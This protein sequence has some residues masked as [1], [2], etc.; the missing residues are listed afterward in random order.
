MTSP[1]SALLCVTLVLIAGCSSFGPTTISRDRFD[2]SGALAKSW[3]NQ[4]L[5]NLVKM[6]Y[7]DLPIYL[8]VGQIVSGYSVQTDLTAAG[9]VARTGAGDTF[10]GLGAKGTFTDR[11]TMTYTP[12][13]GRNSRKLSHADPPGEGVFAGAIRLRRRLRSGAGR[14]FAERAAKPAGQPRGAAQGGLGVLPRLALLRE[15]QDAVRWVCGW[16]VGDAQ[17]VTVLFFRRDRIS[18]D[19]PAKIAEVRK[20]LGLTPGD[21]AFRLVASP[22]PGGPGESGIATRSS[23]RI[24]GA[25]ALGVEI[26]PKHLQRRLAPTIPESSAEAPLLRVHSGSAEPDDA[27]VAVSYEG[28][29]SWVA[30]DDWRSKRALS[31]VLFLLTLADREAP[32]C[33][34]SRSRHNEH[35]SPQPARTIRLVVPRGGRPAALAGRPIG[36]ISG[37][38]IALGQAACPR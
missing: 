9:Q 20:L 4:M 36:V 38:L 1:R 2:Y 26:P 32:S 8:E 3:K 29:W 21:H 33:P 34:C 5:L 24:L 19:V 14:G 27:F 31:S 37:H 17:A 35:A 12:L 22:L 10:L 13:T 30:N 18:P 7:L 15:I 11:P 16:S 28:E 23:A 6:R 25:L